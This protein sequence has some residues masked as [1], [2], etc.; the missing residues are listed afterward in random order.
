M[1]FSS[2]N[3]GDT[4]RRLLGDDAQAFVDVMYE[5]RSTSTHHREPV[6]LTRSNDQALD[7]PDLSPGTRENCLK[8]LHRTCGR[9]AL[10]PTVLKIPV[11]FERTGDA[12]FRGGFADVWK[13]KHCGRDVAVKVIRIYSN[14]DLERVVGVSL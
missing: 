12:L 8:S 1:I 14:S 5:A 3:E 11:P 6:L 7:R 4:I 9:R 10:L 13:G 2:R